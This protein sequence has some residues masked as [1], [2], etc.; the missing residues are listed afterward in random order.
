[1]SREVDLEQLPVADYT[2][3]E[4]TDA[5]KRA[6]R[7]A[8]NARYDK[9]DRVR[10]PEDS[11][12]VTYLTE[13]TNDWEAGLPALPADR[14][15]AIVLGQV[16]DAQAYLS[17]DKSGVYSEFSIRVDDILKNDVH[18]PVASGDLI[19]AE[20]LGGRVRFPSGRVLPV[21]VSGQGMPRKGRRYVLFLKG[22]KL[23]HHYLIVTGYE[24]L[25][26]C[27]SPLDGVKAVGGGSP[28]KFDAY[29]GWDERTFL[30]VIQKEIISPASIPPEN[31]N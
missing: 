12:G 8:K 2:A 31:R 6:K 3:L 17:N 28:W 5:E 13:I 7:R 14:S 16:I 23:E 15:D 27:V 20:R 29:E 24:L 30:S 25:A 26:G 11:P 10:E 1:M 18:S 22:L 21:R 9:E 4:H 19:T